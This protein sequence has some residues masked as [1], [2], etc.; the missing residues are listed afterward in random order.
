[1]L[2]GSRVASAIENMSFKH[3]QGKCKSRTTLLASQRRLEAGIHGAIPLW[4]LYVV[5]RFLELQQH[6]HQWIRL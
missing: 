2:L 3:D 5:G 6:G 1:M 4:R